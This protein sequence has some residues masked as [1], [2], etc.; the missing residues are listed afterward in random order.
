[1]KRY[2]FVT[3]KWWTCLKQGYNQQVA[4]V[5]RYMED[6]RKMYGRCTEDVWKMYGRCM[7]E[8]YKKR[9]IQMHFNIKIIAN[10]PDI[11]LVLIIIF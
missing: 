10:C 3:H 5:Q 9:I 2:V 11:K 8:V 1:M 6:V 4:R 7:E